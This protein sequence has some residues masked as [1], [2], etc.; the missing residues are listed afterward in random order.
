MLRSPRSRTTRLR[1]SR[2]AFS[3]T[4]LAAAIQPLED[5][6]LLSAGLSAEDPG[7][8]TV[9]WSEGQTFSVEVPA[10]SAGSLAASLAT[11]AGIASTS[12]DSAG[13]VSTPGDGPLGPEAPGL[14]SS[15]EAINFDGN[16]ALTGSFSIPPDPHGAAGPRHVLNVTNS[17]IQ[18]YSKGGTQQNNQSLAAFFAPLSPAD[19]TFDPKVIYDQF[20]NRFVVITLELVDSGNPS[21]SPLNTSRFLIAVS[22]NDDPNG[23][24]RFQ[25]FNSKINIGGI[26][27]WF[28]YPGFAV[29]EEAIY[30]TG[31][32]FAFDANGGTFGDARLW[33]IDKGLAAGLYAGGVSAFTVHSIGAV[34]GIGG[35]TTQ[36]AHIYGTPPAGTVGTWLVQYSGLTN[37]TDEFLNTIRIDNPLT[38][39]TFIQSFINVTNIENSG[40]G[41]PDA[42]QS[43]TATLV[44][45]NDRRALNAV[46]RNGSLWTT[47]EVLPAAGADNGQVTAHWWEVATAGLTVTQ[48]GNVGGE[49]IAAG[50][51]TFFPSIA[52]DSMGN[53]ALGFA[54][55]APTIFPGAY[56]TARAAGDAAG[57]VQSS[58]TLATGQAFYIRTFGGP[59]NR[60]GDYTGT[61][62]DPAND[63]FWIFNEYAMT[64][65]TT[66]GGESGRWAT[67]WGNFSVKAL[68][69]VVVSTSINNSSGNGSGVRFITFNFDQAVTLG[70]PGNISLFNHT[71][72]SAVT[73]VGAV[74]LNN[75]TTS[76][77]LDLGTFV[78]PNGRYTAELLK[79]GATNAEGTQIGTSHAIEFAKKSGDLN[80]D[81]ATNFA[82][83]AVIGAN[84]DPTAGTAYRPGDGNG[85]G[86]VNFAD[87][88]VVGGNFDPL[89]TPALTF[90]FGDAPATFPT[91][92]AS[93]GARHVLGAVGVDRLGAARDSEGDGQPNASATG[94]DVAGAPDDEDGITVNSMQAVVGGSISVTASNAGLINAWV[95]FNG[96]GN[97]NDPGEHVL[98]D[99]TIGVSQT[100]TFDVPRTSVANPIL[101]VRLTSTGATG[102]SFAGLAPSGEVEDYQLTVAAP[103]PSLEGGAA[104]LPLPGSP[105]PSVRTVSPAASRSL[106]LIA[107][108][109][110]A[111]APLFHLPPRTSNAPVTPLGSDRAGISP[112]Q[113]SRW[114]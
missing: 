112:S 75:G 50:T 64:Q 47:A 45:T 6:T 30:V 66:F 13:P 92:L 36:P 85:D 12:T 74:L 15:I 78:L 71:T 3:T 67:R 20:A 42:P 27:R 68:A 32:M 101:R 53:M 107:G 18:W 26:D 61:V 33:I 43:G 102:Y 40:V 98:T 9:A 79:P 77:T 34:D 89:V 69:P 83:F 41:L 76:V 73:P 29:D 5:R 108:V 72:S 31:N 63:S 14:L 110:S 65:G 10:P 59:R 111:A 62:V 8:R 104:G 25:A 81:G 106:S 35:T 28:D 96:D 90:D 57:T 38:A 100:L 113:S 54:A 23:T 86:M 105:F 51:Y 82:D 44:E 21:P 24:W 4:G 58:G 56:Y 91:T 22:D 49:D 88:A 16:A 7:F 48:Q 60:W 99:V 97:W 114:A 37:G 103:P 55:S 87:F 19:Y 109:E 17:A 52:V 84:F 80:N 46:W 70:G 93:N 94:D 95:D 39:P 2:L 1:S 11:T